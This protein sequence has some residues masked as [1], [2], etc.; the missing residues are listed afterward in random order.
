M[1]YYSTPLQ[2]EELLETLDSEKY[3]KDLVT[4]LVEMKDEII[5]QMTVTEELTKENQGSRRSALEITNGL[6]YL[7]LFASYL[8][9]TSQF[10]CWYVS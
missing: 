5:R 10:Y 9:C 6:L 3:E 1:R 4:S 7:S 2:L 8:S